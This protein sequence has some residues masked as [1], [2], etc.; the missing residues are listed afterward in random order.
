MAQGP[1][2]PRAG[3]RAGRVRQLAG[4]HPRRVHAGRPAPVRRL[5]GLPRHRLLRPDVEVRV[6]GRVPAPRR[7]AAPGRHRRDRGLGARALRDRPVGAAALRRHRAV[8]AR[9]PTAGLAPGLGLLHLQLRPQRGEELPDLQRLLLAGGVPHRRAAGRRRRL[10]ALSRLLPRG[11]S[12]GAEQVR[13]QREPRGGRA[14]AADQ[15]ARL[16]ARAGLYDDRR[17]VHVVAGRHAGTD[18]RAVSAS[19]SSGTWAG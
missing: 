18:V 7:Q 14:A 2:L 8:R 10:D 11:G 4:L 16:R 13:R 12:V 9:G 1:H 15:Q 6:A 5:L 17:G 19:A 3:R